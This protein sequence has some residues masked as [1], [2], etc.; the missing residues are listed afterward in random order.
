MVLH[1]ATRASMINALNLAF[2]Y[3]SLLC[4]DIHPE[5]NGGRTINVDEQDDDSSRRVGRSYGRYIRIS[6]SS[7]S[8]CRCC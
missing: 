6:S 4:T 5:R 8:N 3:T 7:S 2:C 1:R